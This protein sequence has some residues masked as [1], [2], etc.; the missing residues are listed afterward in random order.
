MYGTEYLIEIVKYIDIYMIRADKVF[1][2]N[3]N[4]NANGKNKNV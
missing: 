3:S 1:L 2:I 4:A